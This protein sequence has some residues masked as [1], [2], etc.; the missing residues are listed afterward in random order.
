MRLDGTLSVVDS[1]RWE[2]PLLVPAA[3]PE[4]LDSAGGLFVGRPGA[5]TRDI[6]AL[7]PW[8]RTPISGF[9]QEEASCWGT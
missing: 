1:C 9:C 6:R 3:S 4:F 2:P 8:D 7:G 5:P